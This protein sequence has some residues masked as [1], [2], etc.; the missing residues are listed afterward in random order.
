MSFFSQLLL[1]WI[2]EQKNARIIDA[3]QCELEPKVN[4][5]NVFFYSLSGFCHLIKV[6][7]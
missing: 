5:W 2:K 7:H 6:E 4:E 3:S 1:L